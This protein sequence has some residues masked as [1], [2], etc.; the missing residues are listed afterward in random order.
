MVDKYS[1]VYQSLEWI[2]LIFTAT[3]FFIAA[4]VVSIFEIVRWP[5]VWF[6]SLLILAALMLLTRPEWAS[7]L[8]VPL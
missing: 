7:S 8:F 2:G 5:W 6:W 3:L 1:R 4:V